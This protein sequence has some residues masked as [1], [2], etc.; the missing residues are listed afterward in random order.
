M[1]RKVQIKADLRIIAYIYVS[2]RNITMTVMHFP[3]C[4]WNPPTF[5]S[6]A[7][8][9][10]KQEKAISSKI[11]AKSPIAKKQRSTLVHQFLSSSLND[12]TRPQPRPMMSLERRIRRLRLFIAFSPPYIPLLQ[13]YCTRCAS[14]FLRI[15][16]DETVRL[17]FPFSFDFAQAGSER[18]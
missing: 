18:G 13:Y 6:L 16:M 10:T 8:F 3:T 2:T 1:F 12:T 5:K 7:C 4:R 9:W 17:P 11:A 14:H 15:I